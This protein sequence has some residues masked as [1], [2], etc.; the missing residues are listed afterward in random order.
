MSDRS[1]MQ[2][3]V[4]FFRKG[5]EPVRRPR[6]T[7]SGFTLVELM[8]VGGIIMIALGFSVVNVIPAIRNSRVE[9]AVQETL[10]QVR[11]ARQ[12]AVDERRV[13]ISTFIP[14]GTIQI[15]RLELDG[16]LTMVSQMTIPNDISFRAETGIPTSPLETPDGFGA[17]DY[18][19]DFNGS[20]QVYFQA[21]GSAHDALGR[22]VNGVLYIARTGELSSSRAVT[23]F[24]ATGRLKGWKL[25]DQG[26]GMF[27][28]R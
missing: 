18:A 28:W 21:D 1:E 23:V 17:G 13:Y 16:T 25:M 20:D 27:A 4:I 22:V 5:S 7:E 15:E 10:M 12:S 14:P 26:E 24:G 3:K 9:R 11:R 6:E 2:E 8:I 19:I